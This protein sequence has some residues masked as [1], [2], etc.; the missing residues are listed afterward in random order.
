MRTTSIAAVQYAA[1]SQLPPSASV[2]MSDVFHRAGGVS[3]VWIRPRP[4]EVKARAQ[5]YMFELS[6]SNIYVVLYVCFHT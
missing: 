3:V 6:L 2:A 5:A 4:H 1:V